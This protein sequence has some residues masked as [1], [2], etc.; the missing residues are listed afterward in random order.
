MLSTMQDVPLT[1]TRLLRH[2]STIHGT[3]QVTTWTGEGEP[4]RR[5]YAE[6][7]SR[8]A[9]LAH[10]LRDDLG[11]DGDQRVATLMWNNAEHVEAYFA[12]PAMGAVLHTLN[13]RLPPEQLAWVVNHAADRVVLVN[14]SLLPLLAPLLPHLAPVEHVIV[15]GPGDRSLLAGAGASVQVHEYE[16]LLA[17]KPESY[18]WPELDERQAAAM[19][20]TSGTTGDPKG[21]VYSH[22]SIYLHAMQV[23]MAQSMGLTDHD[24]SLV[25]VPQFH[26]NAW[27]LPH[28]VFMTGVNMLMPDRF[29]QPAPL[30]EMIES[31]RPSHAAAVPTI[32]Q[33]LLAELTA[34][35]RDISSMKQVTIGGSA[36]PP[37][38]MEAYDKLGVQVCHAWGMTETSPLGTI[39]RVPA[40]VGADEEMGYRLTQGRFPAGV[41]ARL[42]GPGGEHLPWDG[43]SAGELEVRGPWIAGAYYGGA[44]GE[45]FRPADKF[46]EDGWLK[47][48]DVGV[49][50]ANGYL[51]LTDRAKDV[52]KSGGE[53]ISS[54][55][56]ENE[57]MAHPEVAEAA[58]VAVPDDKWGERPLATVV[59]KE[60]ASADYDAL[61]SFLAERVAKWQLPERWAI[62]PAVPKTSVG[63]FDKKVIRRQYADGELDVTNLSDQ[64]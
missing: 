23:N 47:T 31:E 40:G 17:G 43:E 44:A 38:L 32:W 11:V 25:V 2:G 37:A 63:K 46:S 60:G 50:T 15:S 48:G 22:R 28:A 33:G 52:I 18:D 24:T 56:L 8:A 6:I 57:L 3:S 51:T 41:E 49:I 12:I 42:V 19:C 1:V 54:V 62:I 20:Y 30:A 61:R 45:D 9:Q 13:L 34:K 4:Q 16:E 29:L 27:G 36:C 58:V 64:G 10:A 39:A 5:S 55:S 14:G 7:G 26:V 53:W 35:P 21:V 59:L